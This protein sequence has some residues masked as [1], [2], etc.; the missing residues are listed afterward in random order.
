MLLPDIA[1]AGFVMVD[2]IT[3]ICSAQSIGVGEIDM[4]TECDRLLSL[5]KRKGEMAP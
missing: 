4:R 3:G 2:V 1:R 5:D